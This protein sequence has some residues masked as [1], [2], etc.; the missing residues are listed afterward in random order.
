MSDLTSLESLPVLLTAPEVQKILRVSRI[1]VYRM[2]E[3]GDIPTIRF[4]RKVRIP[5]D[6]FLEWLQSLEN[7]SSQ[8]EQQEGKKSLRRVL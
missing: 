3:R 4:G 6:R 2:I 5:R 1:T 8:E 7:S